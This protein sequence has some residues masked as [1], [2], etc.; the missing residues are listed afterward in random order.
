MTI[1][2]HTT[3][4][5]AS[6]EAG[7][8]R[9]EGARAGADLCNN[10]SADVNASASAAADTGPRVY[11][12][13]LAAYNNGIL[14]GRWIDAAQDPDDIWREISAMLSSSPIPNAEEHAF[15]DFEGF[16]K[17]DIPEYAGVGTIARLAAFI[18]ERGEDLGGGVLEHFGGEIGDAEA[19]FE[20]YAGEWKSLA[21]FA[22]DLTEETGTEIPKPLEYYIDW[23]AMG[24]DME[25]SGEI[26]TVQT[27]FEEIHVFWTR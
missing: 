5:S 18:V 7:G 15:H 19:A 6:G 14:H 26:F 1:S 22:Q 4:D 3:S 13:C 21:D 11:A 2:T 9:G 25:M 12:A 17:A 20:D 8:G 24:R 16:G 10:A 23:Q 27:G